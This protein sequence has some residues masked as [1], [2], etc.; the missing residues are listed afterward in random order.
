MADIR[1]QGVLHVIQ[2]A[3]RTYFK[4]KHDQ[5]CDSL[6]RYA[7]YKSTHDE[8]SMPTDQGLNDLGIL[9]SDFRRLAQE[10]AYGE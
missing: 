5:L 2:D 10:A 8:L 1:T 7:V 9:R 3:G 4:H 6:A